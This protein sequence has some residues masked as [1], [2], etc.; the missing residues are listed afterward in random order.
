MSFLVAVSGGSCSGKSTLATSIVEGLGETR[1]CL[2]ALDAYYLDQSHL[3]LDRRR[4]LNY[5]H[6]DALDV[7]LFAGHLEA[8]AAGEGVDCPVYDFATYTRSAATRR[9]EAAPVVIVDGI[10]L[11]AVDAL[12]STF[13][14][15]VFRECPE[16][17]RLERRLLRDVV[18]R[19]R[20][21]PS[22]REQ[23]ATSVKP[24][25]DR[26][27]APSAELADVVFHHD[28]ID[29]LAAAELVVERIL[30]SIEGVSAHGIGR[31]ADGNATLN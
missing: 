20:T 23:F 1:S 28:R 25:H 13:D 5:D 9:I 27:V 19:G 10:L 6:P 16:V 15:R 26:F 29:V 21:E 14:M 8:L 4:Q 30:D 7:D 18:E 31:G 3:T 12:V 17:V 24:M 22:V 2:L 11:L